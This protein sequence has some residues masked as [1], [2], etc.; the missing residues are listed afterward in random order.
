MA[1]LLI[2]LVKVTKDDWVPAYAAE[3]HDIVARH[4][5]RYLSRSGRI[6]T[7]E[8]DDSD[9]SAIAVVQFPDTGAAEA[10][11]ND[12][13]YARHAAARQAG[14]ISRFYIIDDSDALGTVPYLPK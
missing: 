4:G 8:G 14:S 12:P 11:V 2:A 5:G 10:F 6:K 3:V 9:L 1:A 13:A 7:V